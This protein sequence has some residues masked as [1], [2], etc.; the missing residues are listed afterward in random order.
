MAPVLQVQSAPGCSEV[1]TCVI[2]SRHHHHIPTDAVGSHFPDEATEPEKDG[3]T[4]V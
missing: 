4:L 2:S 1:F 3:G